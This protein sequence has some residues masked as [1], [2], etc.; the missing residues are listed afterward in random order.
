MSD[1]DDRLGPVV[2]I[3][4][5]LAQG[6]LRPEFPDI[7]NDPELEAIVQGLQ[8]LAEEL[9]A[10]RAEIEGRTAEL[11]TLSNGLV[12]LAN[13]SNLLLSCD[14]SSEAYAVLGRAAREMYGQLSGAV[15]LYGA[16]RNVVELVTSWGDLPVAKTFPPADCWALRRGRAHHVSVSG[17]EPACRHTGEG[18]LTSAMC[19]P[20]LAQGEALGVLHL[21]GAPD[22]GDRVFSPVAQRLAIAAA[23]ACAL[24]LA[25]IR[26]REKLADQSLRDSL[27]GLYNRRYAEETL[28]REIARAKREGAALS[29][30][31]LDLDHF[32]RVNDEFGHDAGDTALREAATVFVESVRTSDVV[33]R[34][35]GEEF[36]LLL[37]GAPLEAT[38]QKSDAMRERLKGLELFHRGRRM[39][40]LTFSAGAAA[41]PANG[42]TPEA[43]LRAADGALY[44]AK[45]AGR[46]RT[47]RAGPK[48][49]GLAVA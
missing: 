5:S 18:T 30:L 17:A 9:L 45:H 23:E 3:I 27:T 38:L 7:A 21:I 39:P 16:S 40:P 8:M 43:L 20:M 11:E 22:L 24:A 31:M 46:D 33:S 29:V 15:Y 10:S 37:P 48:A 26:L 44:E 4:T 42:E 13:L 6:D 28:E 25:S 34:V 32:K 2:G 1:S 12:E 49:A 36:L 35:G 14:T 19:V 41:F 47:V